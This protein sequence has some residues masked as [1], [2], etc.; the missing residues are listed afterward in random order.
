MC[1]FCFLLSANENRKFQFFADGFLKKKGTFEVASGACQHHIFPIK[2]IDPSGFISRPSAWENLLCVFGYRCLQIP[3]LSLSKS[4]SALASEKKSLTKRKRRKKKN[5]VDKEKS[6]RRRKTV[7]VIH[8][9]S[10]SSRRRLGGRGGRSA[11][12]ATI[13]VLFRRRRN[14]FV[15]FCVF[16]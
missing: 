10:T 6:G 2:E 13:A 3:S 1:C 8:H 16:V 4:P 14:I 15:H 5:R 12:P 7:V 11:D 9:R